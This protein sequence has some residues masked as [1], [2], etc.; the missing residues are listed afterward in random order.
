MNSNLDILLKIS[1]KKRM[2]KEKGV[3]LALSHKLTGE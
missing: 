3:T 1:F 2:I